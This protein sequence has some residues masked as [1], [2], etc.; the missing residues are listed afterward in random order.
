MR[1]YYGTTDAWCPLEFFRRLRD[2]VP[3]LD[4]VVDER[5]TEHA[6]VLGSSEEMAEVVAQFVRKDYE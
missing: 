5:G 3:E 1:F 4:Y 2:A 6:F